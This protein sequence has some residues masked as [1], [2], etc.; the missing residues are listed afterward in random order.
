MIFDKKV[1]L[2][3]FDMM[4]GLAIILVVMGHVM[5]F[6]FDINPSEPSKFIYFNMPLFF[7]ISGYLAY[8][9]IVSIKELWNKIVRRG[10][11]LLFPYVF[12]VCFYCLFTNNTSVCSIILGGGGRYW[13][14][15]DLFII[16]TFFMVY[17]YMTKNICSPW[18]SVVLW[19]IPFAAIVFIKLYISKIQIGGRILLMS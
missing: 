18:K 10:M 2:P 6:S 14:L 12:F 8:K 19:L 16:S 7:Y 11:V 17:E 3:Y 4:K 15:Y 1:Y 13:F 5:L 9:K